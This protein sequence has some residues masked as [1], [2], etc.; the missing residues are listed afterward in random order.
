MT[1]TDS[2]FIGVS[3][4][5]LAVVVLIVGFVSHT[6]SNAF[7]TNPSFNQSAAA[8]TAVQAMDTTNSRFDQLVLGSF[9]G[10]TIALIVT[11][12]YIG[13]SPLFFFVYFIVVVLG[14]VAGAILSNVWES[15]SS[16]AAFSY[17]L[18]VLPVTQHL[19][20]YLPFYMALVGFVGMTVMFAKPYLAQSQEGGL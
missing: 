20:T 11:S 5:M 2:V 7:I 3:L 13:A 6:I 9:I 10:L 19:M 4:F 17:M 8:V 16:Q 14:V 15:L 1:A 12:W 18:G